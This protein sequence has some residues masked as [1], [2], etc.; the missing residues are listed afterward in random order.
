MGSPVSDSGE[1]MGGGE[2]ERD[3]EEL[4]RVLMF[5]RPW[6]ELGAELA[7]LVAEGTGGVATPGAGV[8]LDAEGEGDLEREGLMIGEVITCLLAIEGLERKTRR[9]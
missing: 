1:V 7:M 2:G 9:M 8:A 4:R 3:V 6:V 5:E